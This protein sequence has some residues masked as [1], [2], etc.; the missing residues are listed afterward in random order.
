MVR[1]A[2]LLGLAL[3]VVAV[4]LAVGACGDDSN[5]LTKSELVTQADT[6]CR[7]MNARIEKLGKPRS[8]AGVERVGS[9]ARRISD[10]QVKKLLDLKAPK[11]FAD[12]WKRLV[13]IAGR[14]TGYAGEVAAAAKAK[15]RQKIR[16]IVTA[17]IRT[18]KRFD[19]LARRNGFRDCAA[20]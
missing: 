4:V 20:G 6:I 15:D 13:A 14:A 18:T 12:E 16:S 1:R 8:L 11:D 7:S 19:A 9:Q 5:Q 10:E 3:L 17:G 2:C